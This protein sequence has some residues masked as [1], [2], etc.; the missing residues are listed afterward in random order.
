MTLFFIWKILQGHLH[1]V[2]AF[3]TAARWWTLISWKEESARLELATRGVSDQCKLL[4]VSLDRSGCPIR[5][6]GEL[7]GHAWV[8]AKCDKPDSANPPYL[9]VIYVY[10]IYRMSEIRT[11]T[12]WFLR[13]LPLPLG[14]HPF[15]CSSRGGIWTP[16]LQR[17]KMAL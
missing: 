3:M 7:L 11:H 13:P 14:Y 16:D 6:D 5:T 9:I 8:Q 15:K 2:V 12:W 1:Q 17:V 10:S 4:Y